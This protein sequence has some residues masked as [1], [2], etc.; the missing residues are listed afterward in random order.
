MALK[1]AAPGEGAAGVRVHFRY[2]GT[3]P[4]KTWA[5]HTAG[6]PHWFMCHTSERTKPCVHWMSD[7]ALPCAKCDPKK[8]AVEMAYMPLYRSSDGCPV[9][10]VIYADQ[11]DHA[12]KLELHTRVMI[13]REGDKGDAVYIRKCADQSPKYQSTLACR[14]FAADL[15]ETLLAMWKLPDLVEWYR[16]QPK[17]SDNA[18]SPVR[19]V[20][21]RPDGEPFSPMVQ[22][23]AKKLG[24][25][26]TRDAAALAN[27]DA[28]ANRI[29]NK[30]GLNGKPS[31]NGNHKPGEHD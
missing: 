25:P 3:G 10:V 13:G 9:M 1:K 24:A 17:P 4:A 16:K 15:T 11:R 2:V 7:G 6:E 8:P 19:E 29:K 5:A 22:K 31:T 20:A 27:Y 30:V 28:I 21:M 18:V 26:T 23:L 14:L 12:D